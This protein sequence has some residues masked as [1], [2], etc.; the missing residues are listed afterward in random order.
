M[1]DLE[2]GLQHVFEPGKA[3]AV[4]QKRRSIIANTVV[5][6]REAVRMAR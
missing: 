6:L 5:T 4:D 1:I 3:S 2:Q